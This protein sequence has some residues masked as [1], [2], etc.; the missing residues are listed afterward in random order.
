MTDPMTPEHWQRIK[1]IYLAARERDL[2]QRPGFLDHACD[3]D[4]GLRRDVELLLIQAS[5]DGF[6]STPAATAMPRMD[7]RLA[8]MMSIGQRFGA[9]QLQAFL[10]AGGMGEVY[11]ARDS[12]LGRDVAIKILPRA[13]T[14][15]A[16]RRARF[17]REARLLATLNHPHIGAIYGV[18]DADGM[19]GLVL[20]LVE[21][22]TLAERIKREP[23]PVSE[24]LGFA[25]QIAAAL[26]AAHE[27]GIVHRDLKPA[28]IKITPDG[29]VKVLDF[30]LAK[31][32]TG[33]NVTMRD[34]SH[35][36]TLTFS[37]TNEGI[38]L[39]TAPYMSPEQARGK[40]VDKRADVW[41][42]GCVLYEML[43]GRAAFS[44]E[45]VSDTIAAVLGREVDWSAIPPQVPP[46]TALLLRRC[47]QK[48]LS[49]RLRDMGDARLDL[50]ESGTP[51]SA[52]VP[53]MQAAP[54]GWSRRSSLVALGALGTGIVFGTLA[55][56]LLRSTAPPVG[57][58]V[59]FTVSLPPASPLGGLD[60]PS[61]SISPDGSRL[62][63]VASRG[64][65]TQLFVRAL[66]ALE[67]VPLAGTGNAVAP[68]FSPDG[69]WVAFFA[70]GQLKKVAVS[71]GTPIMLS[72]AQV[73]LGGSWGA[74]DTILFAATT[75]SPLSLVPATGGTP[76]RVTTLDKSTGE[77]SHRWPD[78]LPD[79]KTILYTV[80]TVG[81]WNDAQIVAQSLE[82]GERSVLVQGGT[83]PRYLPSGHLLYAH[84]GRIMSVPFDSRSLKVTGTAVPVLENVLQS[85]DGAAQLSVSR[86]G[87]A[88]YVAGGADANQRRLVSVALDGGVTPIAAPP[89]PYAFPRVSPNGDTLLFV[90]EATSQDVWTYDIMA[91]TSAQLTFDA[92]ATSPIW[93]LD[94]RGAVFSSAKNG[95]ANLF[96]VPVA[97]SGPTER[98]VPSQNQQIPG[99]WAPDGTLAYVERRP[100]T[101]RD[102]LLTSVP[103]RAPRPLVGSNSDESSPRFSSD[104][105]WLAYVSND[106]GRNEVYVRLAAPGSR[107]ERISTD[108]GAEPVWAPDRLELFYR[109]GIRMMAVEIGIRGGATTRPRALFEGDFVRGTMDTANY[110]V[111]PNR[112][113]FVMIQRPADASAAQTTLHVLLNWFGEGGS[114]PER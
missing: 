45:T 2:D 22:E 95:P 77:F 30:G 36:P 12:K 112:R 10:G 104:G 63:Y 102:I 33:D 52:S 14:S 58:Q 42:F 78:W 51:S 19:R 66:N 96:L 50:E 23:L 110:D 6:L 101:G 4:E 59:H 11:Q 91:G 111:M 83:S 54:A 85:T 3:G 8:G 55:A 108:G 114:A 25:R 47:L 13:F 70:D 99:A 32:V 43:T 44:G 49:R 9:Y 39:G 57:G 107:A 20:E 29:V 71:G 16:D 81:S 62:A 40:P 15:D 53:A 1:T 100:T 79:G 87:S 18:E 82:T 105:R 24:A 5:G 92:A 31:A 109:E 67:S 113:G 61:V 48:D 86:S 26:D 103:N 97:R 84:D 60:F 93:T 90:N 89:G 75:G 27:K 68:F 94:G 76:R 106:S 28:N 38:I 35:S 69:L 80:G 98:L 7:E 64:G 88:V 41:A 74:N 37:G 21:G 65:Q 46:A 34:L 17:E 56:Q 73:G 72:E